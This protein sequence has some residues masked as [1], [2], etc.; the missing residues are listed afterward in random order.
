[1]PTILH[2]FIVVVWIKS[3]FVSDNF[4]HFHFLIWAQE[5]RNFD[6]SSKQFW[7][8][9][10]RLTWL[11]LVEKNFGCGG[12]QK[13]AQPKFFSRINPIPYERSFADQRIPYVKSL[14]EVR[15]GRISREINFCK[16]KKSI[17]RVYNFWSTFAL[18]TS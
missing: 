3:V 10:D 14:L 7:L 6:L 12:F 4:C 16:V 5:F 1:M 8:A 11:W 13:S 18:V 17:Y 9:I 2:K 15:L